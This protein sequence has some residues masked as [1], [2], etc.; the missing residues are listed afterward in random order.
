M[1]I[2]QY[3]PNLPHMTHL[4]FYKEFALI[5]T[6]FSPGNLEWETLFKA[7][8]DAKVILTV[9][10]NEDSWYKSWVKYAISQVN[11]NGWMTRRLA[12]LMIRSKPWKI[13]VFLIWI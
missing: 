3:C 2:R 8:P 10:D 6:I 5:V 9:R 13:F 1:H 11:K 4:T 12:P 7:I